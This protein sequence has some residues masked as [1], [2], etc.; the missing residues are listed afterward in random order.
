MAWLNWKH[1]KTLGT[2]RNGQVKLVEDTDRYGAKSYGV[3]VLGQDVPCKS[4]TCA[5]DLFNSFD[6]N[7]A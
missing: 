6:I 2:C 3:V 4:L 1:R 5:G 7:A